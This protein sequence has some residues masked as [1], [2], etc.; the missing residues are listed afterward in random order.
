[1]TITTIIYALAAILFAGLISYTT[2]P[3]VQRFAHIVGAIDVPKDDRRMH[4]H[5]IP[6]MGGLAIFLGFAL[7]TLLFCEYT[8]TML[9]MWF[10]GLIIVFVGILDDIYSI[11]PLLKLLGQF[12]AALVATLQGMT[13]E[14]VQFFGNYV[15]FG[16]F[17][18]PIT[19]IWI[20]GLTNAINLID[21]LDG[22]SCGVST[23][24]SATLLT[25]MLFKGDY[26]SALI[27]AVLVG[28]CLGFLPFNSHPAKIFMGDTGSMFLGYTLSLL[29]IQGMF[30][31][32]T[33][34]SFLI[35][36]SIF[37][38]PLFDTAFA[39]IRRILHGQSPFT[40]D[41]GHI[42]HRLIRMGLSQKDSGYTLY[43][44]CGILGV[45]AFFLA[46][47]SYIKA[48]A[49]IL[50]GFSILVINLLLHNKKEN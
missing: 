48:L 41:K 8:P 43:A 2:T 36:L 25:I 18:I 21:G 32:D 45:A 15:E 5:P 44:I 31:L 10:G 35:P 38:L 30:K 40:P 14:F 46:Y 12:L 33:A 11:N 23:I 3:A 42:H 20:V 13:I 4:D 7:T 6:R 9:A 50:I 26:T 17:A 39:F 28:S 29:S 1:M 49:V 24:C 34:M 37:G 27:T 22:L 47:E 19:L 16:Y